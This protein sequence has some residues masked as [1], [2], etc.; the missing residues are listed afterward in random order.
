MRRTSP[1]SNKVADSSLA[2][3]PSSPVQHLSSLVQ[4]LSRPDSSTVEAMVNNI[5]NRSSTTSKEDTT[6]STAK[7]K[8]D[9]S[10]T[11]TTSSR[12][13]AATTVKDTIKGKVCSLLYSCWVFRNSHTKQDT[14][15]M[16][17]A[18]RL[19]PRLQEHQLLKRPRQLSAHPSLLLRNQWA[20]KF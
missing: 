8:A 13:M 4:L 6:P 15:N 19:R 16:A 18:S 3:P 11:S 2:S 7:V 10:G 1:N 12:A 5:S 14:H 9:S 20:Q 17:R